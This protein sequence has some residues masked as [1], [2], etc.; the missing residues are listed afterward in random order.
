MMLVI[1]K[2]W[3][4][5]HRRLF[6]LGGPFFGNHQVAS[7]KFSDFQFLHRRVP[8]LAILILKMTSIGH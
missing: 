1:A 5:K 8:H 3:P 4:P 6:C 7:E 2:E